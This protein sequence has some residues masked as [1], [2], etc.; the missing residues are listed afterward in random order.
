MT[1]HFIFFKLLT[2]NLPHYTYI[3]IHT[4]NHSK[5]DY[6]FQI[7]KFIWSKIHSLIY[8]INKSKTTFKMLT[9][10]VWTKSKRKKKKKSEKSKNVAPYLKEKPKI[11]MRKKNWLKSSLKL[12]LFLWHCLLVY[13]SHN[14]IITKC[15]LLI[16]MIK[17]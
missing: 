12:N 8:A 4:I 2:L 3:H 15:S 16:A 13:K 10:Y 1:L 9:F 6:S 14:G 5:E 11:V 7:W 17:S